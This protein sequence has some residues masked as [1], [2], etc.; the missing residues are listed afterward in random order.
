MIEERSTP[1]AVSAREDLAFLRQLMES[2]TEGRWQVSFGRIYAAWGIGFAVPITLEWLRMIGLVGL[3]TW[4]WPVSAALVLIPITAV[5]VIEGR[6]NGPVRGAQARAANAIFMGVG[7]ANAAV[8]AALVAAAWT[9]GQWW[10]LIIHGVVVFAFQGGAWFGVWV[11][12]KRAWTGFVAAGWLIAAVGLGATLN[13]IE[14]FVLIVLLGLV[15]L[16]AVPGVMMAL[17][18]K[19]K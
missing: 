7:L 8:L 4:F 5:N 12:R 2:D 6:R 3:P 11:L 14:W 15:F 9:T 19:P 1:D 13:Y 10:I 17:S 18:A 16:M